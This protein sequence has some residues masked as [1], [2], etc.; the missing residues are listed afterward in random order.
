MV[1]FH[2]NALH[3]GP[4]ID[5]RVP[6][7]HTVTLR[8]FGDEAYWSDAVESNELDAEQRKIIYGTQRG[9]LGEPFRDPRFMQLY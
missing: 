5:E 6:E 1:F 8:F 9:K 4:P 7:R 2:P 3:S